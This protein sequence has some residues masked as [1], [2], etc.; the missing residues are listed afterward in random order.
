MVK[1]VDT[2]VEPTTG[3]ELADEFH[4]QEVRVFLNTGIVLSGIL[5]A[6]TGKFISVRSKYRPKPALINLDSVSSMT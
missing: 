3:Y 1:N 6:R 2:T 5:E 4:G